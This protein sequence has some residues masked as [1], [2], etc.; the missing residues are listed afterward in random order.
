MEVIDDLQQFFHYLFSLFEIKFVLK[1]N[2]IQW[3]AIKVFQDHEETV[4]SFMNGNKL[5]DILVTDSSQNVN[6]IH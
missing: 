3:R 4:L 1:Q 5:D 2:L 6:F